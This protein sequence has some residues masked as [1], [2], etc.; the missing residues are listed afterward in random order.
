MHASHT[1]GARATHGGWYSSCAALLLMYYLRFE[2]K[3]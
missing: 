2:M 1:I 3:E